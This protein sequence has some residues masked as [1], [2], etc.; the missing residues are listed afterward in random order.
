MEKDPRSL[1]LRLL[2][3]VFGHCKDPAIKLIGNLLVR[4]KWI[5]F[6]QKAEKPQPLKEE[7]DKRN[8]TKEV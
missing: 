5:L 3:L 7:G 8:N 6:V 4:E 2:S 1:L